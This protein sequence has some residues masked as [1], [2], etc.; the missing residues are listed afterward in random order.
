MRGHYTYYKNEVCLTYFVRVGSEGYLTYFV[1]VGSMGY[2]TYF[3][4]VGYV[5]ERA[6]LS[7]SS[8]SSSGTPTAVNFSSDPR[9]SA[10]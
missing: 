3:V 9:T 4:R 6:F 8:W 1:R 2:L 10:E 7:A 5:L